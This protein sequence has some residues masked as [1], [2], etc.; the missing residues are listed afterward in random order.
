M[1]PFIAGAG[2]SAIACVL[3]HPFDVVKT[4]V[5]AA[6]MMQ[7]EGGPQAARRGALWYFGRGVR[8][9]CNE[10]YTAQG[11][12][13]FGVGMLPRLLKIVPSCAVLLAT[14]EATKALWGSSLL[15][16]M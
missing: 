1:I 2:S 13:G 12:K 8:D 15:D 10:V 14:Y 4:R 9:A 5:Q 16:Q 6:Q 7:K 3:T 11:L